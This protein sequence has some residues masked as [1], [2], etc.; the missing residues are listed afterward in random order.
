MFV[1]GVPHRVVGTT[2]KKEGEPLTQSS[3]LITHLVAPV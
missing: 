3:V 1:A 2:E